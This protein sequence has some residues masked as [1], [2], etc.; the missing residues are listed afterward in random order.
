RSI[1][2]VR[3]NLTGRI[4]GWPGVLEGVLYPVAGARAGAPGLQVLRRYAASAAR[5][6]ADDL[7]GEIHDLVRCPA[8]AE[9]RRAIGA[10]QQLRRTREDP[11]LGV[12][13]RTQRRALS[14]V[15]HLLRLDDHLELFGGSVN[16]KTVVVVA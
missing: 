9:G 4:A 1:E 16:R 5:L 6:I 14:K 8:F 12:R 15:L 10:R 7:A 11:V 2:G 13:S 3:R